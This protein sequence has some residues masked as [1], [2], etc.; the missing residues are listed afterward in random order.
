MLMVPDQVI[1]TNSLVEHSVAPED[2]TEPL[3]GPFN[4]FSVPLLCASPEGGLEDAGQLVRF[5]A[6][7]MSL[8]GIN[9]LLMPY[10]LDEEEMDLINHFY[11]YG[12]RGKTKFSRCHDTD[13]PV[14]RGRG[15]RQGRVLHCVG[16]GASF[17]QPRQ[18]QKQEDQLLVLPRP[19]RQVQFQD[20]RDTRWHL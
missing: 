15:F 3:V 2:G 20:P 9:G 16:G 7:G 12:L 17:S 6:I 13:P 18:I 4:S 19:Q 1:D 10:P 14:D 11:P 8:P 5:M